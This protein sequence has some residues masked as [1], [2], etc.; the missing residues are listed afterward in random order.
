[1]PDQTNTPEPVYFLTVDYLGKGQRG[2]FCNMD[3]GCFRK[4]G[5]PHT[6]EEMCDILG[7]F[8]VILAPQSIAY[9]VEELHEHTRWFALAEYSNEFGVVVKVEEGT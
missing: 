7:P 9:T 3:G 2:V 5:R 8:A 6:E 1:M 4:D